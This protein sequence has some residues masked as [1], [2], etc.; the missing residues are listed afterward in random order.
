[1]E[2]YQYEHYMAKEHPHCY[3]KDVFGHRLDPEDCGHPGT[4]FLIS[5]IDI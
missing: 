1:M 3:Q 2:T 5:T 4:E